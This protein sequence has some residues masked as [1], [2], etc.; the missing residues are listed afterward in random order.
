MRNFL[1]NALPGIAAPRLFWSLRKK[2]LLRARDE[3]VY[4]ALRN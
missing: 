2:L 1:P 4:T 3:R